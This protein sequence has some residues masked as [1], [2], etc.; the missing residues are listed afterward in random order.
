MY[1]AAKKKGFLS[2]KGT[3]YR[4][5]R[6]GHP[7][8]NI[9]RQW[10]DAHGQATVVIEQDASGDCV[11]VDLA[12]LRL[13]DTSQIKQSVREAA[14]ELGLQEVHYDERPAD[15]VPFDVIPYI[16]P[17]KVPT[18]VTSAAAREHPEPAA[19]ASP[20]DVEAAQAAIDEQ[21]ALIRTLKAQGGTNQS[22]EVQKEVQE[23]LARKARLEQ[24]L[25]TQQQ[26]ARAATD[27]EEATPFSTD[28][29]KQG[30]S[31]ASPSS[32]G[33]GDHTSQG[34]PGGLGHDQEH[35][36]GT[37][38]QSSSSSD[39]SGSDGS[40]NGK[41]RQGPLDDDHPLATLAIWQIPAQPLFFA[42]SRPAAKEL[43]KR[44]A[45]MNMQ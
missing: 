36:T 40:S 6:K 20:E 9:Y 38:A 28:N 37:S 30:A 10:C 17:D 5:Q 35:V 22:P 41:Q 44:V 4:K 8:P 31:A 21:G 29:S 11:V 25:Q 2:V 34:A 1:E 27:G 24:L 32:T 19:A 3:G 7:L 18:K 26:H 39:D 13:L 15:A 14:Q 43:A 45:A 12:T 33:S 42:A 16:T 23:L